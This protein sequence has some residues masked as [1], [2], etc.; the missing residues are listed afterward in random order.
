MISKSWIFS[1][2]GINDHHDFGILIDDAEKISDL[3]IW[4]GLLYSRFYFL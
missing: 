3:K 2:L 1:F 4:W